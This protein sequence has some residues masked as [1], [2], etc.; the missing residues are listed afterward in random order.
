MKQKKKRGYIL[1][2]EQGGGTHEVKQIFPSRKA[3]ERFAFED[4]EIPYGVK[5][6][7]TGTYWIEKA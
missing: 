3:A 4:P 7:R 2:W 1:C 5:K 6:A